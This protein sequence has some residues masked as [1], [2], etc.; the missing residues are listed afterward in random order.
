M[1]ETAALI[2]AVVAP[3]VLFFVLGTIAA[4]SRSD[5]EVPH[6]ITQ[7]LGLYLLL[8]IGF[9][10][11][12]SLRRTGVTP[13]VAATLGAAAIAAAVVP[14][15]AYALFRRYL[16]PSNAAA[17]AAAYGS[18]SAV[19]FITAGALLRSLGIDYG[20]HMVAAMA[21]M[22]SP[23]IIV[24]LVLLRRAQPGSQLTTHLS[25]GELLRDAFLNGSVLLIIGSLLIGLIT[26]D[27]GWQEISPFA[28]HIFKGMLSVFLLDMGIVAA[29]QA[30]ELGRAGWALPACGIALPLVNASMALL[31]SWLLGLS[32][33]D[34]VLFT[35][36][37]AS[38]SYIAVPAAMRLA[39]PS[40][41]PSIYV[42][43][44]LGITFPFNI[45]VGIPL[46]L[47]AARA[48]L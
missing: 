2:D 37:C 10:G 19:T 18:V 6:A 32:V 35:V 44:A 11:G 39:I 20:G 40:A 22:E 8:S 15:F 46:Y 28:D 1:S 5:L 7:F 36:L 27:Q 25:V 29:R 45:V 31:V 23:A 24:A 4:L 16:D 13:E 3:P 41:S 38:A 9:H 33:G 26:G 47:A 17:L 21:I 43:M 14:L 12:V 30:R 34:A 48:I 42:G